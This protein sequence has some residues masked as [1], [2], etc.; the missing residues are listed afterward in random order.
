MDRRLSRLF[1][2]LLIGFAIGLALLEGVPS[3]Q[4]SS[5]RALIP[6]GDS[7]AV[8]GEHITES[9]HDAGV[10]LAVGSLAPGFVLQDLEGNEVSLSDYL[11]KDV[12]LN[13]WATWCGPCRVEMPLFERTYEEYRDQGFVILGINFDEPEKAVKEFQEEFGLTF[14]ILLDPGAEAQ[15]LYRIPGYPSSIFVD[16]DGNVR[17]IHI[18]IMTEGQLET[19][20]DE[21]GIG[22]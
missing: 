16:S 13:F 22:T 17:R 7:E 9:Q 6:H 20:L 19:Y 8:A 5:A 2:G 18:G 15:N 4:D 10:H 14:P 3:V 1:A 21:A 11:G 12:L